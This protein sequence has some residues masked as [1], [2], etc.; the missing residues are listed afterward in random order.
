MNYSS[1]IIILT[2]ISLI[3]ILALFAWVVYKRIQKTKE[4]YKI[5]S[6]IEQALNYN[7][8]ETRKDPILQRIGVFWTTLLKASGVVDPTSDDKR[9]LSILTII[10]CV[11]YLLV[12]LFTLNPVVAA[13]GPLIV[14]VVLFVYCQMKINAIESMISAQI[15]SFLSSLKSNIQSNEANAQ[16]LMSAIKTTADPLYSELRI[17]EGLIE[18]GNFNGA[19][20][21]L[22]V[23]TTNPYLIFLCSCIELSNEV[24]A[25]LED[26]LTIIEHMIEEK[27]ALDRKIDTAVA[28]NM[29]ILYV[30]GAAVPFLFMFT[31]LNQES[32]RAFWFHGLISWV[33][34][35]AVFIIIGVGC[36]FGY[37]IIKKVRTM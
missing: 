5:N 27:R 31:Y 2:G 36:F 10:C 25:N 30:V 11:I 9:N 26:Q 12:F 4:A 37:K 8:K 20:K 15:P 18:T 32:A 14:L 7:E 34:F 24:G 33:C 1:R 21:A 22:R 28:E 3:P 35:F 16:A 13:I 29:P 17:V 6:M 19:L 23:K